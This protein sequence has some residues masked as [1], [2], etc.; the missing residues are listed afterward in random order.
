MLSNVLNFCFYLFYCTRKEKD[1]IRRKIN[2]K[3]SH[4]SEEGGG[5]LQNFC[6]VFIDEL[7]KLLFLKKTIEVGQ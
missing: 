6:L 3:K 1:D 2:S 5:T 7:E 4:T